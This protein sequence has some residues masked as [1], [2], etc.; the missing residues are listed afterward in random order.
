MRPS[1]PPSSATGRPFA[2][3]RI[4]AE[5]LVGDAGTRISDHSTNFALAASTVLGRGLP[6]LTLCRYGLLAGLRA[7]ETRPLPSICRQ[8]TPEHQF[9]QDDHAANSIPHHRTKNEDVVRTRRPYL[10]D[11]IVLN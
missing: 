5:K 7:R 1:R 11:P 3:P 10:D 2:L 4:A 9:Q 6:S 8:P